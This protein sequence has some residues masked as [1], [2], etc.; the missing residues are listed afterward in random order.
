MVQTQVLSS[1]SELNAVA[2]VV[3]KNNKLL[4]KIYFAKSDHKKFNA[5]EYFYKDHLSFLCNRV[6]YRSTNYQPEIGRFIEEDLDS[7][8]VR[9]PITI[10][11]KYAYVGNNPVKYVDPSGEFIDPITLVIVG[12]VIGGI[13][14]IFE[15]QRNGGNWFEDVLGGAIEGAA[16][17]YALGTLGG[18]GTAGNIAAWTVSVKSVVQAAF[19][20]KGG[21]VDNLGTH[22][23]RNL[24]SSIPFTYSG[25]RIR[26]KFGFKDNGIGLF[27]FAG[28]LYDFE[29]VY[30][31]ACDENGTQEDQQ[32]CEQRPELIY[33]ER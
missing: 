19:T 26:A 15:N 10:N 17:G 13:N 8:R 33:I 11:N 9:S 16:I 5:V 29:N 22:G 24:A 1:F 31:T 18:M 28:W 32:V 20:K 2:K 12:A 14:G 7:G 3:A 25:N 23:G 30:D 27:D 6:R 4:I 21:F